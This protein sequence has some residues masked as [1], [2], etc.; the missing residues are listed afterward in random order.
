MRPND[1]IGPYT[2][3]RKLGRG[4]FGVVWLAE[5]RGAFA[6]T[7]V[8]VKLALD[9]DAD[10]DAIA[11]ESQVWAQLAG[12][13]NILSIIEADKYDGQ[14]VIVSEYAPDGS[15][16]SW[17]KKHGGAAPSV[18]A[19][20]LMTVGILSG[21]E[22]L[23]SQRIIH[24]DL[25][26]ANILLQGDTP[27]LAD[28]GLARVLKSSGSSGGIA[29]TPAYMSP[30]TFD[31]KRLEQSDL[32]SAGV[33]FYQLLVGRLPFPQSEI[34][35]L[36]GA[37]VQRDPEPLPAEIPQPLQE[38]I[39]CA[40]QKDPAQRFRS[41]TEMRNALLTAYG[42]FTNKLPFAISVQTGPSIS[43]IG[44][45][46]VADNP[47]QTEPNA[48]TL[49]GTDLETNLVDSDETPTQA[50]PP[51]DQAR[52]A[53]PNLTRAGNLVSMPDMAA[54]TVENNSPA[55]VAETVK[56]DSFIAPETIKATDVLGVRKIS[57][58]LKNSSENPP[59]PLRQRMYGVGIAIMVVFMCLGIVF[60]ISLSGKPNTT[61]VVESD[62]NPTPP[63]DPPPPPRVEVLPETAPVDQPEEAS[64]PDREENNNVDEGEDSS[65]NT[66]PEEEDTNT[67]NPHPKPH[68]KP[69]I[70]PDFKVPTFELPEINIEA[71]R[72]MGEGKA[73]LT[74]LELA[75]KLT[76]KAI[77]NAQKVMPE[78]SPQK[79]KLLKKL[80]A[81]RNIL[82]DYK[83]SGRNDEKVR[84]AALKTI[85]E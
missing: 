61:T 72:A 49:S 16:E 62:S 73:T 85:I 8:A 11:K 53:S 56:G 32:W 82:S 40:L 54:T 50:M 47:N 36:I 39:T 18:E 7:K 25:K 23:H 10:L 67:D 68:A 38:I 26:P 66:D 55:R 74:L 42:K 2:L 79:A 76:D 27:R 22:H 29:G 43:S 1:Q 75:L 21:L 24:R 30:E 78:D 58:Q 48:Q 12:H 31:G 35:A 4:A 5:R 13:P 80:K 9:E 77:H 20:V 14:V 64:D 84:E 65:E 19:A 3:V 69:S 15:L 60:A 83:A 52:F 37:I 28:F 57:A 45:E 71:L 46:T 44:K 81:Q 33:I 59:T 63:V 51:S 17:L 70:S 34:T 41:A 6:T